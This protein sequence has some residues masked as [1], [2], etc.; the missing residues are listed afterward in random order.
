VNRTDALVL[1]RE[2]ALAIVPGADVAGLTPDAPLRESLELDSLDF[3]GFIETL[4]EKSGTRI[5]EPEYADAV[6]VADFADIVLAHT[7]A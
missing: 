5:G 7:E 6:T 4:G 3:L 2:S 1:V